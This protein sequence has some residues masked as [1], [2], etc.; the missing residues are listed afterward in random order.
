ME[1]LAGE[2]ARG[3]ARIGVLAQRPPLANFHGVTWVN[4][5]T[6]LDRYAH[7]LYANLRALDRIGASWLLVQEIPA[8]ERWD[9]VRDRLTRA[10]AGTATD[11]GELP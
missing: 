5:G 10:A 2:L 8:D 7:D 11:P 9:A 6:R 3:G 4:A 1:R